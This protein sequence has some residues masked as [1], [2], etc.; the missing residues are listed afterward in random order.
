MLKD[1]S[2]LSPSCAI[3]TLSSAGSA[4]TDPS[5]AAMVTLMSCFMLRIFV[6]HARL[7]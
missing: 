2:C 6:V 3:T 4:D 5:S 7:R 1:A